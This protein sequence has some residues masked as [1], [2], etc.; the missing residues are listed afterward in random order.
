MWEWLTKANNMKTI[1]T[2]VNGVASGYSAYENAK[3]S[4]SLLDM[5][6]QEYSY[7]LGKEKKAQSNVDSA[8]TSVFGTPKKKKKEPTME[9]GV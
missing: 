3:A 2:V 8:I 9:I 4:K 1:G 7:Q 6:K 5:Q